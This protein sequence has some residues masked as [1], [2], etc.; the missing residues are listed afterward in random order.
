MKLL[1]ISH[2]ANRTGASILAVGLFNYFKN[3]FNVDAN[4][5]FLGDGPLKLLVSPDCIIDVQ[6]FYAKPVHLFK[7]II[8][9]ILGY[10]YYPTSQA[11]A[12]IKYYKKQGF[13]HYYGN[14]VLS[15]PELVEIHAS[16]PDASFILHVHELNSHNQGFVDELSYANRHSFVFIAVSKLVKENLI[17][18]YGITPDNIH[19]VY[20]AIDIAKIAFKLTIPANVT[21]NLPHF[22]VSGSGYASHRKGFD[23][24]VE[25]SHKFKN[26]FPDLP[27]YFRWV[28][29]V[30]EELMNIVHEQAE[31]NEQ[32][33]NLILTGE[34]ENPYPFYNQSS[35]FMLTSREDP[36]PLVVLEHAL[37]GRPVICFDKGTGSS[38]FV[39]EYDAGMV[40][41]YF[42]MDAAVNAI[43]QLYH[44]QELYHHYAANAKAG[45]QHF[46]IG[47]MC[48][49]IRNIVE[50]A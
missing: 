18:N 4:I 49:K 9:K 15:L 36:F 10:H 12:K 41:P 39:M 38:E 11:E 8:N 46:D 48:D 17:V 42:Q 30:S 22:V 50:H 7:R 20:G 35:V 32:Q 14:S 28:G 16:I 27:V 19:L 5:K 25:L 43:S 45:A 6:K 1:F 24:F 33:A 3:I 34:M 29:K 23:F 40:I 26:R 2:D 47:I 21:E 37:L 31:K 13:T 44:N